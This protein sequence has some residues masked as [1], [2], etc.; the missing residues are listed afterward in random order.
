[1]IRTK[2]QEL[3]ATKKMC[4]AHEMIANEM[5]SLIDGALHYLFQSMTLSAQ[6][7]VC[8]LVYDVVE[9][10]LLDLLRQDIL[11]WKLDKRI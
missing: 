1:M 10:F 5:P 9:Q 7:R 8:P 4:N 6:F 11:G 2:M 3:N